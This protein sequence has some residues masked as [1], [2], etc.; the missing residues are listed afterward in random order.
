MRKLTDTLK[1][2]KSFNKNQH[3]RT[4]KKEII[5]RIS[6]DYKDV[7]YKIAAIYKLKTEQNARRF[8][9]GFWSEYL[10]FGPLV[11][12]V[13]EKKVI[14]KDQTFLVLDCLEFGYDGKYR[15]GHNLGLCPVKDIETLCVSTLGYNKIMMDLSRDKYDELHITSVWNNL[16]TNYGKYCETGRILEE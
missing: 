5:E 1:D 4:L 6:Y 8:L 15:S 12:V 13:I 11:R 10:K 2:L 14:I 9:N 7:D 16:E 3:C